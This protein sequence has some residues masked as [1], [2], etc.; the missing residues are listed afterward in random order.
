MPT[1]NFQILSWNVNGLRVKGRRSYVLQYIKDSP[2]QI[3]MIQESHLTSLEVHKIFKSHGWVSQVVCSNNTSHSKGVIIL[4]KR[5]ANAL[6]M[7]SK[8]D[9]KGRW[10]RADVKINQDIYLL[11][12]Y[13]GPNVDDTTAL[14]EICNVHLETQYPII[15]AG[16]F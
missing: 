7:S 8:S 14:Q 4:I 3:I 10:V 5:D 13:Y 9:I 15:I 12:S 2:A 1:G 16:D 6:I 11:V